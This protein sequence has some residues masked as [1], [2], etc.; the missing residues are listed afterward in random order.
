MKGV[1]S[2]D[3]M[4]FK[5]YT[6]TRPDYEA[7][8]IELRDL[9]EKLAQATSGQEAVAVAKEITAINFS[10]DS[11]G[12]LWSIRHSID[13]ND[14]FYNEETKFWNE[15]S[16][17]FQELTTDYYKVVLASPY[18]EEL[19][20]FLP[21]TFFL[22]AENKL[23]TFS[24]EAIPLFQ[25]ENDL[26]D[27]YNNL[28]ATAKIE[29]RGETYNLAQM[30]P[31]GQSTDRTTRKEASEAVTQFFV[32][33]EEAF[34][35]IYDE[36][37]KVRHEIATSLGFK[38][39][40]EYGY[41]MMNRFDYDR[42][43]VATY[44]G[45]ILKHVVPIVEELHHRQ[46]K[47]I[48]LDSLKHYDLGLEY[49]DGNAT[50]KGTPDELVAKAQTMYRELSPETGDFFDYMID[51]DLLDLVAKE[52][53][54]T[55][56]YCTYIPDYKSPFIFANFNGTSGD[57]DVLT[58][59]AGHAFQVYNSRWVE[60][61][62]AIWP[63]YETCEIHSMS[64]EFM[65]WPWMELFFKEETE[66]YKFS[67][68]SGALLFLPYG[69]LVDHYQ[70]EVYENPNMTPAE[71]KA[72]WRRL[73]KLYLPGK[74]YSESEALDNGIFW[75]RQG[76][77]FA[78]PFYYIDYT[79]AQVCA[80]Q[81]W[82]R[83]QIDHD[84]T[85]WADYLRICQMGGTGTFLQVVEAAGIKSPFQEGALSE[86]LFETKKWLDAVDDSQF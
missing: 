75:Y 86:T 6:Y 84:V 65:T 18:R 35:E 48:G 3:F 74:D 82:K 12:T 63:T 5:D 8:K 7:L 13:M 43:M 64:M 20:E 4:G 49:L 62:E 83:T 31:F 21:E 17:L 24:S 25:K 30:G 81:F 71:R 72:T 34:D 52:G 29:F 58:H 9:T 23:A 22:M 77:I 11:Q 26:V 50:P 10:I 19:A 51:N 40:V 73:E 68:L 1:E 14:D 80:L 16:P 33:N 61:P 78:A 85:A 79:L 15:Y 41:K 54:N 27:R 45:E 76:H 42:E 47:R 57:I 37:V 39:Y 2:E 59:E 67:H 38:D 36:L 56:G 66:K 70:H 46:A 55:G 69:V 60:T 28:M 44:R 53:K 32:Q